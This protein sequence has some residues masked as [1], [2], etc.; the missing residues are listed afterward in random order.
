MN[1]ADDDM[2]T[3][4]PRLIRFRALQLL[5]EACDLSAYIGS[6]DE[7]GVVTIRTFGHQP[8][9]N[10]LPPATTLCAGIDQDRLDVAL[11]AIRQLNA[12]LEQNEPMQYHES[13][14]A[15]LQPPPED[16]APSTQ[17][18]LDGLRRGDVPLPRLTPDQIKFRLF[19]MLQA[20][21]GLAACVIEMN[22]QATAALWAVPRR[23]HGGVQ[24]VLWPF[25]APVAREWL[26]TAVELLRQ[27]NASFAQADIADSP[28]QGLLSGGFQSASR[29]QVTRWSSS[30]SAALN[31]ASR[32]ARPAT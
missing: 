25:G 26:S 14:A 22:A 2:L 5:Q 6:V 13:P 17:E 3:L 11:Q 9:C 29:N 8:G 32:G 15:C 27:L 23:R 30:S 20:L 31:A 28:D 24:A 12:C 16:A 19:Q 21:A 18:P 10:T 7:Q 4:K 1:Q